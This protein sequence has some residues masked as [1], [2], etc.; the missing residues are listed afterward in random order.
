MI[1]DL[2]KIEKIK[3]TDDIKK[4]MSTISAVRK[5]LNYNATQF[6]TEC[7]INSKTYSLLEKEGKGSLVS[8]Y[9]VLLF[10]SQIG[11][12]CNTLLLHQRYDES[13]FSKSH[14]QIRESNK[15]ARKNRKEITRQREEVLNTVLR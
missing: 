4:V 13:L 5:F 12:D 8:F 9:K 2:T 11:I 10:L 14:L 6:A 1:K 3:S 7:G 15:L